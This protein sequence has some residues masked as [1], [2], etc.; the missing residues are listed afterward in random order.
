MRPRVAGR[1]AEKHPFRVRVEMGR[2]LAHQIRKVQK[3]LA[4]DGNRRY[5]GVHDRI[6]VV[7]LFRP[8]GVKMIFEP[9]HGQPRALRDA[10]HVPFAPHRVTEGVHAPF[11][12]R[13]GRFRMRKDDAARADVATHDTALHDAVADG[14]SRLVARAA[15]DRGP[16]FQP[17]NCRGGSTDPSA[18]LRAFHDA[19][20]ETAF[21]M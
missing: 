18:A 10:H 15:R 20:Q 4:S 14:G 9:F 16:L 13:T 2:T 17:A 21:D 7:R 19:R 5:V 8:F 12:I 3:P 1:D 11:R 6:Y